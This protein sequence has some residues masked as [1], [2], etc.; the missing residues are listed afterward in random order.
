MDHKLKRN[1]KY[2]ILAAGFIISA[3]FYVI[4]GI[5]E[6]INIVNESEDYKEKYSEE[7]NSAAKVEEDGI[8]NETDIS[9][10]SD[11]L[12]E[13]E[14]KL[15]KEYVREVLGEYIEAERLRKEYD[16]EH[17]EILKIFGKYKTDLSEEINTGNKSVVKININTAGRDELMQLKGIGEKKA[18]DILN[19]REKHGVFLAIEELKNIKGIKA[20]L[21]EKIKDF[22]TV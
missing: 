13:H 2:I 12:L 1:L 10:D 22:I 11:E 9:S 3:A 14:K 20:S 19:Y 8:V 4:S 21:Y 16:R 5:P 17:A 7:M 15:I 6:E 18:E